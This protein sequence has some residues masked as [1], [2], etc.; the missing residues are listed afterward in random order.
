MNNVVNELSTI[1]T[2]PEKTL[3]KV[4]Q[5]T[6]YCICEDVYEDT[7]AEKE[8][9]ELDVGLGVLYFK[10]VEGELKCKFVPSENLKNAVLDVYKHKLNLMDDTLNNSL[11]KKFTEVYKDLC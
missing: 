11:V 4:L 8:I 3:N 10:Y 5:K 6:L 7:I 1:T 2:I 9:T